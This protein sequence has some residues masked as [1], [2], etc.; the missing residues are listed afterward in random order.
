MAC[1]HEQCSSM[2]VADGLTFGYEGWFA[3]PTGVVLKPRTNFVDQPRFGF[4]NYSRISHL[5]IRLKEIGSAM[6]DFH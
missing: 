2:P 5:V 3:G 4:W 6:R 1:S